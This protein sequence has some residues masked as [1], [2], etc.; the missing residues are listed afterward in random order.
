[1]K[2][3]KLFI[4]LTI[5]FIFVP[6]VNA[7]E[8]TNTEKVD[9]G[10]LATSVKVGYEEE[11]GILNKGSF[12]PPEGYDED[13]YVAEYYYF[14]VNFYNISENISIEIEND[15]NDEVKVINYEDT[16][17]GNYSF[18]WKHI[19][20]ITKFTYKILGAKETNCRT[21]VLKTGILTLPSYNRY[22]GHAKCEGHEKLEICQ[23]YTNTVITNKVFESKMEKY[24]K[25]QD[26][27]NEEN[28]DE[29]QLSM[30][31]KIF[32]YIRENQMKVIIISIS[33]LVAL[34]VIVGII[35][36]KRR[37]RVI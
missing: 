31:D 3:L 27:E 21:T 29:T 23:K 22:Y 37:G 4:I 6:A 12:T 28:Y 20:Q 25:E 14:K 11:T 10:K 13:N 36:R 30:F 5:I 34:G 35:I 19:N 26:K 2:Y 7:S 8:C 33:S 32:K 16:I 18:D 15:Y 9:L 17:N 1:M 24:L